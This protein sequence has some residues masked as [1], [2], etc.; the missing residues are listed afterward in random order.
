[1]SARDVIALSPH[2]TETVLA[3]GTRCAVHGIVGTDTADAILA[4]LE[5]AGYAVV[6]KEP[7]SDMLLE[8]NLSLRRSGLASDAY[9]SMIT[10]AKE[11]T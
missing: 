6:P 3:S 10:A 2:K 5:A 7:T 11:T 9:K 8:G 4:A 1:M